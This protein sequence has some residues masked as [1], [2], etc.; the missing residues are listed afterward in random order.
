MPYRKRNDD[1]LPT[2]EMEQLR[3][4]K[5]LNIRNIPFYAVPNGGRRS[6]TEGVRL[7]RQGVSAGVPDV[8]ITLARK[9]Y[10]GLYIELKRQSGGTVSIPQKEWIE[11]LT[12][13][14]YKAAVAKGSDAAIALVEEY[15]KL[16]YWPRE[17]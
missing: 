8:C 17:K 5:Y 13:Q 6:M 9:P 7:K 1:D 3:L 15:L 2:E 16:P 14:G 11:R 4:V 12:V 10:H